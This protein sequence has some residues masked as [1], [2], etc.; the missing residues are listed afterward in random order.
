MRKGLC[1]AL[2]LTVA[3]SGARAL[4][5]ADYQMID[6]T[7][8]FNEDTIYWPTSPSRFDLKRLSFGETPGGWFYAANV[9]STPEHGGTHFDAP[10][11]FASSHP[12]PRRPVSNHA[13]SVVLCVLPS[14]SHAVT[15]Q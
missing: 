2:L 15:S 11:H 1:L 6:L 12:L 10:I 13:V 4:D 9:L 7:H 8:P 14:S 5:L 3:M